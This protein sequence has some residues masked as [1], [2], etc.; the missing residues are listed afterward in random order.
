MDTKR[1]F[2]AI[3]ISIAGVGGTYGLVYGA[4]WLFTQLPLWVTIASMITF[5]IVVCTFCVYKA[6]K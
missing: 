4:I 6:L 2:K 5:G 3:G 1:L